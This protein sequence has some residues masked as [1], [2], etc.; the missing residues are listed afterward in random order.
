M[1][2]NT[3]NEKKNF[4]KKA[5]IEIAQGMSQKSFG[6]GVWGAACRNEKTTKETSRKRS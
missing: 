4:W 5:Q 2:G 1:K 3:E 6:R